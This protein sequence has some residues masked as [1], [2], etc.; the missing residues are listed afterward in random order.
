LTGLPL[1]N[2]GPSGTAGS[3]WEKTTFGSELLTGV[4]VF[5]F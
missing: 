5:D 4:E 2:N 3:H 1:E